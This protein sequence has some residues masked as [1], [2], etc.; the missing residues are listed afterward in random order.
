MKRHLSKSW[1]FSVPS[2]AFTSHSISQPETHTVSCWGV[3]V[4]AG[5]VQSTG[6]PLLSSVAAGGHTALW[7]CRYY[8]I[9]PTDFN[10]A[11]QPA[12]P[13]PLV[14]C[15]CGVFTDHSL[16]ITHF[17][18]KYCFCFFL[19]PLVQLNVASMYLF[20]C[21]TMFFVQQYFCSNVCVCVWV[22]TLMIHA[23]LRVCRR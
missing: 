19:S 16:R 2:L 20:M 21:L 17:L 1:S 14:I 5:W 18:K 13:N 22:F 9:T 7:G 23:C 3:C 8:Y 12:K 6:R 15:A 11:T 10:T 4:W